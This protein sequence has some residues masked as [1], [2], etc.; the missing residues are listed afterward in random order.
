MIYQLVEKHLNT[1]HELLKFPK[2]IEITFFTF[3]HTDEPNF[4]IH[5][6]VFDRKVPSRH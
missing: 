6:K 5:T 1:Y 3:N 2:R 4:L